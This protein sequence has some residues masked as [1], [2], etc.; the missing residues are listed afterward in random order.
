MFNVL[1]TSTALDGRSFFYANPLHVRVPAAPSTSLN[2]AAEGGLRSPW[3]SVSCCPNNIARTLASLPAYFATGTGAGV[4]IHQYASGEIRCGDQVLEVETGYP[5]SGEVRVRASGSGRVSLRVPPWASG[6]TLAYGGA[7]RVVGPGYA[8]VEVAAGGTVV[9]DLPVAPR[10]TLPDRRIDAVRG[11]VAV[12]RGTLV[13]CAESVGDE[14][15]LADVSVLASE[16]VDR[17][18]E[19][20]VRASLAAP[21]LPSSG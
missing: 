12:E 19:V 2:Q 16:P 5:W 9:L 1:A 20:D 13:Y 6:A 7:V 15:P 14:P 3:F 17:V 4:Q 11:S 18:M 8:H 21:A 10:W